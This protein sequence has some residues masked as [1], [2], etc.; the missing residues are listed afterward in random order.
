MSALQ[1]FF[2]WL[3]SLLWMGLIF[4]L[5]SRPS[6]TKLFILA[7][8]GH[9]VEYAVLAIF[10]ALALWRTTSL[11]G[12]GIIF[13]TIAMAFVYGITDELHQTLVPT[14]VGNIGDVLIDV[15]G[16]IVGVLSYIK[17]IGFSK[18]SNSEIKENT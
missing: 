6:P 11:S 10:F 8:V 18:S 13:L 5:S 7:D 1:K 2:Y 16:A 9:F 3:P 12:R 15:T 17:I 4:Y 14:R